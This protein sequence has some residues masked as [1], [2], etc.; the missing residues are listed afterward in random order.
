MGMKQQKIGKLT[1]E[2]QIKMQRKIERELQIELGMNF[3]RNRVHKTQKD[4]NRQENKRI[5]FDE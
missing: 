2:Q 3:S 4:Y 1:K 5:K